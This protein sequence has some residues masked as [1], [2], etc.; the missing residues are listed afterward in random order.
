M[1]TTKREAYRGSNHCIFNLN[2]CVHVQVS[3]PA[4][5][6][7]V[8]ILLTMSI[9]DHLKLIDPVQHIFLNLHLCAFYSKKT[10][11]KIVQ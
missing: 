1:K 5:L 10:K 11:L 4:M 7:S 3:K 9:R 8:R 2:D 6:I